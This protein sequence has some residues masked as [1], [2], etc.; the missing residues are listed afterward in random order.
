MRIRLGTRSSPLALAQT[1][2]VKNALLSHARSGEK[3]SP[4]TIDI[5]PVATTGDR[6]QTPLSDIGGKGLFTKELQ[7]ALMMSTLHG[8][9]HSLKDVE[10]HTLPLVFG[11]FLKR[12]A[13]QDVVIYHKETPLDDQPFY[14]GTC[15][16]RRKSQASFFFKKAMCV[17]LRGNV[18]TRLAKV[19]SKQVDA[20]LLALAG[21]KRLGYQTRHDFEKAWTG[22]TYQVLPQDVF[23]P[24]A[25]QGIIAVECLPCHQHMFAPINHPETAHMARI[26]RS[27]VKAFNGHCRTSIGAFV[28][29][30][31]DQS[32]YTL[33]VFYEGRY[34]V[35]ALGADLSMVGD[36]VVCP[37]LEHMSPLIDL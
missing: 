31:D 27:V 6:I 20:I 12:E 32:T 35:L 37:I 17:D 1:A 29:K 26:E 8:A 9:V 25:G 13:S 14:L 2:L 33:H 5:V 3:D 24:A 7:D 22:L 36:D 15:A 11:A 19:Q 23:I 4:L 16:P 10:C 21:L 18:G 28:K 30:N 34:H